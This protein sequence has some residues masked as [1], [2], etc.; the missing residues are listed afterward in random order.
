MKKTLPVLLLKNLILLPNQDVKLELTNDLSQE[1]V[2]LASE[3]YQNELIVL[4]LKDQLEET[5]EVSDLPEIAVV[6]KVKSKIELPNG[7]LRVTLR[8]LFRAKVESLSNNEKDDNILECLFYKMEAPKLEEVESLA[9][10]RKLEELL[11]KYV[12]HESV[13]N[14]ILNV[15]KEVKDLNKFTD[16]LA[17][18][19]PLSFSRKLECILEIDPIKR[20]KNLMNDLHLEIEVQKLDKKLEEKLQIGLEASQKEFILKEKLREIEEELGTSYSKD[21]EVKF[22]KEKLEALKISN[23]K[24]VEKLE[25]EIKKFQFMSDTSPEVASIRNYLEWMTNLPWNVSSVDEQDIFTIKKRLDK[26]H[27]GMER[28]KEKIIEYIAAKNRSSLVNSPILCLIGPSGVGKTT[29]AKSIAESLNREFY[30]ISVG[31]LNDSSILNGHRRTYMGSSP[32]KIIEGLKKCGTKNPVFLIDEVDKMVHDYKGDPASTLLDILDKTQNEHFVDNYIE[33]EFDLSEVLFVLTANYKEDIPYELYDRLEVVDLS[34]YTLLEKIAITKKHLLPK[35]Y[36]EHNLHSKDI[37]IMDTTLKEIIVNY[38]NEA[39]VR[40]L[41]RVLTSLIRKL[42]VLGTFQNVQI[43]PESLIEFLGVGKYEKALFYEKN[44]PGI[45]NALAVSSSKG[46]IIPVETSFYRGN[47]KIKV[48][49]FVEKVME[50]S[51]QVAISYILKNQELFKI[52]LNDLKALDVHIHLLSA[53]IKK[54]GSS[55]GLAITTALLSLAKN[56]VIKNNI[57]MTGEITLNGFVC[58]IGSVKEK[59]I[60]AYNSGIK[61]VFIPLENH[62][63]LV[64]VPNEVLEKLEIIE[65]SNYE[66]IYKELFEEKE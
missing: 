14:S 56:R 8:G 23:K 1:V 63:D 19:L 10:K 61:K 34:S 27:F 20:G 55:A 46:V 26:S 35:I 12:S 15:I 33:E 48:T 42:I 52:E 43:K 62:N 25:T 9:I 38:T 40:D 65:I 45:V 3:F 64:R 31:G 49:G 17:A 5:P 2:I 4:P 29:L 21:D 37:K 28:A 18:F 58:R 7:N 60:G 41:K 30:K 57:A 50:E 22:Y 47:G 13:S 39:G 6:A 51:I 53:G 32:G 54:D 44:I 59:L 24:I 16:L 36:F 66:E 11:K